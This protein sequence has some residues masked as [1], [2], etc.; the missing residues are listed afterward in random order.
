VTISQALKEI[1][2]SAPTTQRYIDTLTFSHSLFPQTYYMTN[3]NQPWTFLLETG[4]SAAFTVMPFQIVLPPQDGRGNQ[5]L[6][7]TLANI[8]RDLV[9][10]IEA[11]IAKPSE[12]I[13]CTYRVYL[14]TALSIPQNDPVLAMTITGIEVTRGTVSAS[15]TRADVLN[16]AFPYNLYNYTLFPGLRR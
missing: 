1:Y 16:R 9:D 14:D 10:P 15:A 12:P 7:L 4:V 6:A 13:I 8:G 3:D 11:A 5:D 2:A